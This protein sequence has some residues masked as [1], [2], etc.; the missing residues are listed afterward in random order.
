MEAVKGFVFVESVAAVEED[1]EFVWDHVFLEAFAM[2][3]CSIRGSI[4]EFSSCACD[5]CFYLR[6]ERSNGDE[7]GENEHDY[8]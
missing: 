7:G 6:R 4:Y 8:C 2:E 5:S 3:C 1:Y